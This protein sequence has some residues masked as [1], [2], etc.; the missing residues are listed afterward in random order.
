MS[1]GYERLLKA[2]RDDTYDFAAAEGMDVV[3]ADT[4]PIRGDL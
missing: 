2:I 4:L 1:R 3:T